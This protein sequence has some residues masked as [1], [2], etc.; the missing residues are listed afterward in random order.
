MKS[1]AK[2]LYGIDEV[3]TTT[4]STNGE[5]YAAMISSHDSPV[6]FERKEYDATDIGCQTCLCL[7]SPVHLLPII[8]GLMGTKRLILDEEEA[9]LQIECACYNIN[10]RR[11]YG[12]L[13]SVDKVK[14][15]CCTG[16]SSE[17]SKSMP[18]FIGWGCEDEQVADIVAE[19]KKR[20]KA[21]GDTGQI[22]KA[23]LALQEIRALRKENQ[24]LREDMKALLDHFNITVPVEAVPSASEEMERI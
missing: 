1:N 7:T 21:R 3:A 5:E 19:L 4:S 23:E 13:G 18:I 11:P 9:V 15:L 22:Q 16:V 12:E 24:L 10:T 8:P 6:R 20:M 2:S 14:Y 17:L